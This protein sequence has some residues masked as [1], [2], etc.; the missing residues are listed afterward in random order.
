MSRKRTP[1][2]DIL[3]AAFQALRE[4]NPEVLN[5]SRVASLV[6]I[7][8]QALYSHFAGRSELAIA[9]L[10]YSDE[11]LGL[12]EALAPVRAARSGTELLDAFASFL[13]L[14]NPRVLDIARMGDQLRRTD[15]SM[16]A[17]VR[18]RL[19]N[20]R[21]GGRQMAQLLSTWGELDEA[22]TI[23]SAGVWLAAMSSPLVYGEQIFDYGVSVKRYRDSMA[24]MFR[25]TLLRPAMAGTKVT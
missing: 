9:L 13:S 12:E 4:G 16:D 6:G 21:R 24:M 18:D 19:E 20:R 25:R 8:R 1:T 10:R 17:A 5:M 3:E 2:E 15:A 11:R 22:W 23:K 14:Y 7:S